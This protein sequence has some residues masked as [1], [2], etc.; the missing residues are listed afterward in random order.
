[1]RCYVMI[2]VI[3]DWLSNRYYFKITAK[4]VIF[5]ELS[6]L[7]LALLADTVFFTLFY[8]SAFRDPQQ[9]CRTCPRAT[10]TV[11]LNDFLLVFLRLA[12]N[13]AV[14]GIRLRLAEIEVGCRYYIGF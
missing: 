7:R 1:M 2:Y 12:Q 13:K 8:Q 9:L 4:L 3:N 6:N 11:R 10:A 14:I 5:G